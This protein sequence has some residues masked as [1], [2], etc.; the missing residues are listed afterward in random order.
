MGLFSLFG[1]TKN[2]NLLDLQN[3]VTDKPYGKL[4]MSEQQLI[5]TA[6]QQASRE[7]EI[8]DD[9][10]RILQSTKKPDVFFSRLA[11][12]GN[13]LYRLSQ[14]ERHIKFQTT[15]PSYAFNVYQR[16]YQEMIHTFLVRYYF[17]IHEQAETLKTNK[18]K[19]NKYQ[20]FYDSLQPYFNIMS[21]QNIEYV[22]SSFNG[23]IKETM[24]RKA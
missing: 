23:A 2:K 5:K 11:L 7:A 14:F 3:L 1:S 10:I 19:Q 6:Y 17:D 22:S 20:K 15:P 12:L 21:Q 8:M 24:E 13:K 18:A 4:I 9:C 16:E